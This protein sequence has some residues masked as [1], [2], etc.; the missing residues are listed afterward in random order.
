MTLAANWDRIRKRM[1]GRP[2]YFR[3]TPALYALR[4]VFN[5]EGAPYIKGAVLDA[6]AGFGAWTPVLA[7]AGAET[8][9]AVDRGAAPGLDAV[10]D[11]KHLPYGDGAFEVVFCSQVLEHDPAPAALLAELRRVLKPGGV[12]L[13]SV[14]HLSR[15][16]DAPHDYFRF[17]AYGLRELLTAAGFDVETITPAGGFLVFLKHNLNVALLAVFESLPVIK[18]LAA[19]CACLTTPVWAA[20]DLVLDPGG[21]FPM[22]YFAR[23]RK[24]G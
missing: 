21:I 5:R 4:R 2:A 3:L 16:H 19:A 13:I 14:P 1:R 6:G 15:I 12:L 23:A 9:T 20:L 11:L 8:V 10:A 18:I 17:T 22:N 24:H 7:H